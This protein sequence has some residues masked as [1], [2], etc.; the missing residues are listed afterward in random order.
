M[1][2]SGGTVDWVVSGD[3][4]TV[5]HRIDER[6]RLLDLGA[7]DLLVKPV[8]L[9]ELMAGLRALLRRCSGNGRHAGA[10]QHGA[11]CVV[12]ARR[13]V[14]HNGDFIPLTYKKFGLLEM[15]LRGKGRVL[16]RRH[17][18]EALH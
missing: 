2:R 4:I 13:T 1:G 11:L 16:S 7:D 10:L 5:G 6:I 17:L 8:Q 14:T 9:E 15:L 18:E 3:I 12:P